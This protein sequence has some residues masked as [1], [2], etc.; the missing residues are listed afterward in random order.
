MPSALDEKKDGVVLEDEN[1]SLEEQQENLDLDEAA[2]FLQL[3]KDLDTSH[4]DM[5]KVRR[6]VDLHVVL[7]LCLVFWANFL[8][9]GIFVREPSTAQSTRLTCFRITLL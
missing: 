4:I 5:K 8:D 3:H 1:V 6:K 2:K 7:S 9:K